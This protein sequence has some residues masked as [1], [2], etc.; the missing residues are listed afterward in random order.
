MNS[1]GSTLMSHIN[2]EFWDFSFL[3]KKKTITLL[4]IK[5]NENWNDSFGRKCWLRPNGRQ[6]TVNTVC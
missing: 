1:D 5:I 6:R 2:L 3:K 4:N